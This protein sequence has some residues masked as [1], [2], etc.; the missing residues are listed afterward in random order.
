MKAII[1]LAFFSLLLVSATTSNASESP[2]KTTHSKMANTL[3]QQE[4]NALVRRVYEIRSLDASTLTK[5]EKHEIRKEL[6]GIKERLSGPG[7]VYIS[8]GA[9]LLIIILLII[10]L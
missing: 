2:T 1:K 7:G 8:G 6:L 5:T 3:T 9:L 10:F 4:A